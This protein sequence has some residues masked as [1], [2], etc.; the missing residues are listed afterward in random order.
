MSVADVW[1]IRRLLSWTEIFFRDKS[2]ENPRL[3][4]QILLAHILGCK[5]IDLYVRSD[6]EPTDQ[7]RNAFKALIK[8]RVDGCPVAYL[9]GQREFYRLSFDVNPAVLIPRPETEFV[10]MECLRALKMKE[11]PRVLDVGTG[12]GCIAL[13]I[14][15]QHATARLTATDISGEAL[16][17]ARANAA[18]HGLSERIRFIEGDLLS[19]VEGERFD[20]IASNPPYVSENEMASLAKDVRD[21]EPHLALAGGA[22]GMALYRRLIAAVP[23]NLEDGGYIILEIGATQER[24]VRELI[25]NQQCFESIAT[26]LDS[27]KLPRVVSAQKKYA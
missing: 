11:S 27:Q 26:R 9:V 12:S 13:S 3:E 25:E 21:F 10:V 16:N 1:P 4:A 6:D 20:A 2:I 14:A 7:Q 5:K 23:R 22:D 15:Q 19:P 18:K 17:V 24:A 8:K